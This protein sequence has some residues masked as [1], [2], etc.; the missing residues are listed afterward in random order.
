MCA[1][2]DQGAASSDGVQR[3]VSTRP[4]DVTEGY[5]ADWTMEQLRETAPRIAD[6]MDT[7]PHRSAAVSSRWQTTI[8]STGPRAAKPGV[9]L[10]FPA[11]KA[12]M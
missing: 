1:G 6:R 2:M 7:L 3:A 8:G 4:G 11:W 9:R 5:A 12:R 10:L